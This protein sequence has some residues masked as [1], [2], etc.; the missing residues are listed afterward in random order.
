MHSFIQ[1]Y[2][3]PNDLDDLPDLV[4][5]GHEHGCVGDLEYFEPCNF[6]ILQPGSTVATSL[7]DAE[8]GDKCYGIMTVMFD[9]AK[10][11]PRFKVKMH[12]LESVRPFSTK[13]VTIDELLKD[14]NFKTAEEAQEYLYNYCK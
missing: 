2:L 4:I 6:Y 12:K 9:E 11:K 1:Q 5:W 10:E 14:R 13:T 8:A 7:C 3:N